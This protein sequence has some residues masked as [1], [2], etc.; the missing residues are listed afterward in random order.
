MVVYDTQNH[1]CD[2]KKNK[3]RDSCWLYVEN[4]YDF[5]YPEC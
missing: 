1:I 2:E 3:F 5:S 4:V